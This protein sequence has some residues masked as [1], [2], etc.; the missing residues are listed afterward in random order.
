AFQAD[1]PADTNVEAAAKLIELG[2]RVTPDPGRRT[3]SAPR[4][5]MSAHRALGRYS[6]RHSP[7]T[8]SGIGLLTTRSPTESPMTPSPT[9]ITSP[10]TS[11]P[12]VRGSR[13]F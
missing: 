9:W 1:T 5:G 4:P 13:R 12:T 2:I 8:H 7:S 10:A 11:L 3:C 6:F